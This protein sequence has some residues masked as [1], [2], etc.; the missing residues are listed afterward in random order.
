MHLGL[1]IDMCELV[2]FDLTYLPYISKASQMAG[3]DK[4]YMC[5]MDVD[6][7]FF[8]VEDF[9]S[10]LKKKT[11]WWRKFGFVIMVSQNSIWILQYLVGYKYVRV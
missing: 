2:V 5:Q 3:N 7:E 1:E 6:A 9:C 8:S 10:V 4:K 11:V